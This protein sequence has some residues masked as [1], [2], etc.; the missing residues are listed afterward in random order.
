MSQKESLEVVQM[1]KDL[2]IQMSK[3]TSSKSDVVVGPDIVS[4]T[5]VKSSGESK[6]DN[7]AVVNFGDRV[8]L[9]ARSS[10]AVDDMGILRFV[11]EGKGKNQQKLLAVPPVS[12]G[13]SKEA[14]FLM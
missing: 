6:A 2:P 5:P 11:N 7:W 12:A 3:T 13:E 9:K 14:I 1:L 4:G 10:V 8:Y